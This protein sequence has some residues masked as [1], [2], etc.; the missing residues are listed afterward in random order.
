M[1]IHLECTQSNDWHRNRTC[2]YSTGIEREKFEFAY[3][4]HLTDIG[5]FICIFKA[6]RSYR[7]VMMTIRCVR[8]K[9]F[10]LL[11]L[12]FF[13]A[14]I[15]QSGYAQLGCSPGVMS[16]SLVESH[17]C[18]VTLEAITSSVTT[19]ARNTKPFLRKGNLFLVRLEAPHPD[20]IPSGRSH[21]KKIQKPSFTA[22]ML[23]TA[24]PQHPCIMPDY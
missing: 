20:P 7:T 21:R 14:S 9:F 23:N 8:N 16:V 18:N 19:V 4:S 11:N 13:H 22:A 2:A 1:G 3:D 5:D 10:V 6:V 12:K 24:M 15:E 17:N